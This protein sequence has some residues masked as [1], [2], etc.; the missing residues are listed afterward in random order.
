MIQVLLNLHIYNVYFIISQFPLASAVRPK[1]KPVPVPV[2]LPDTESPAGSPAE[3]PPL[4]STLVSKHYP[5]RSRSGRVKGGATGHGSVSRSNLKPLALI[6]AG[7]NLKTQ[8]ARRCGGDVKVVKGFALQKQ[9]NEVIRQKNVLETMLLQHKRLR[10]DRMTIV[11]DMQRMRADLDRIVNKLDTS[12]QSLNSTRALC[13]IEP[14][15]AKQGPIQKKM[16]HN[17]MATSKGKGKGKA[18][19]NPIPMN[20]QTTLANKARKAP[21]QK[22]PSP[23]F[24]STSH[25]RCPCAQ[26]AKTPLRSTSMSRQRLRS[27]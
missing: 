27:H 17:S 26:K 10:Q 21:T 1:R 14:A 18:K 12:L 22:K 11:L 2:P 19:S 13:G 20:R 9:M 4:P 25:H 5:K 7:L 24:A 8:R 16:S 15:K 6:R 23:N 3:A